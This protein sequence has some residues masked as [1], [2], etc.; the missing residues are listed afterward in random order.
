[1]AQKLDI[2]HKYCATVAFS[3][4]AGPSTCTAVTKDKNP[5]CA[6]SNTLHLYGKTGHYVTAIVIPVGKEAFKMDQE[7]TKLPEMV[8][9]SK[10]LTVQIGK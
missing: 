6:M 1:M 10:Q 7:C 9:V 2:S 4:I 3:Y 8:I 5:F